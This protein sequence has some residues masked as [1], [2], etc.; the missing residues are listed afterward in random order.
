[1]C[2]FYKITI[3]FCSRA[4][5]TMKLTFRNAFAS[6][7]PEI[8]PRLFLGSGSCGTF[9][10]RCCESLEGGG[11]QRPRCQAFKTF[12][13]KLPITQHSEILSALEASEKETSLLRLSGVWLCTPKRLSFVSSPRPLV[14]GCQPNHE[15]APIQFTVLC[16]GRS[17]RRRSRSFQT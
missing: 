6:W 14:G 5:Q 12:A 2:F 17:N 8:D 9:W 15:Q 16:W 1:M 3:N 11:T 13:P 4:R 7:Y 10:P